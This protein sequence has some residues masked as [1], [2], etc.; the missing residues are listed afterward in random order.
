MAWLTRYSP[1][2]EWSD[3]KMD[4]VHNGSKVTVHSCSHTEAAISVSICSAKVACKTIRKG[5][6]AWVLMIRPSDVADLHGVEGT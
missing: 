6:T 4:I 1:K 5:A 3:Y 2:I